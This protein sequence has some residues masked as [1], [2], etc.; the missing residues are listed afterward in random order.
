MSK[1]LDY[2]NALDANAVLI[3]SHKSDPLKATRDFGLSRD[4][5]LVLLRLDR[6]EI[7]AFLDIPFRDF[8]VLDSIVIRFDQEETVAA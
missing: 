6:R 4:E 3:Q 8:D 7:S 5:Q 2:L 1:V